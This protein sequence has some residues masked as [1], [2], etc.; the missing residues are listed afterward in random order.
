MSDYQVTIGIEIHCELKTKTKMFSGA[1]TSFGEVANTQTSV[2][3]L[4]HPGCLPCVNK[5]AVRLA[6]K[7][8]GGLH[9]TI[10]PLVK[11]DRKN[12]YYSDLPKGFQITQQFHPIGKDGYVTIQTDEGEKQVRVERIHMEEDTAKQF[13]K[14]TGTYIDFNRAGTPLVEIVSRPDM[15]SAQEAAA[16][17]EA[18]RRILFYLNVSDVKMEEGSMRCDVNISI[19]DDPNKLGTKVEIKNLNSIANVQKAVQAEIERQTALLEAGEPIE[20]ATRRFDEPSKTTILMRKK[21]GTVDYKYFPEPNIFPIQLDQ[22]WIDSILNNL[23]ELPEQRMARLQQSFGLSDYDA[24]VLVNDRDMA[25]FYEEVM[26]TA[27]DAKKAANWVI[28]EMAAWLN[29][30]NKNFA[31]NPADAADLARLVN[32]IDEGTISGK[33]GKEVFE[34]LMNGK[35]PDDVIKEKGMQQVSD[36]ST[37]IAMINQVLDENP[38][39]IEDFKN[40]K[41]R[42]VGFLMGQVMKASKGQANPKKANGLLVQELNKR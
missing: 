1:P 39:S 40:G 32:L 14:E 27:K 7:A 31:N 10:D 34:E 30:N 20:Q 23:E 5:E 11:F 4:G 3:D 28:V 6:I 33:Q 38:K 19:S 8:C 22:A 18:L 24:S 2:I 12:Y 15:H 36:D 17:V 29:K 37:L 16:Y 13:H 26:K 25:D 42:A 35:K 21:E 41:K 9:C